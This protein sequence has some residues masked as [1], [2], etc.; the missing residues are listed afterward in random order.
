[1]A[2]LNQRNARQEHSDNCILCQLMSD[3][4]AARA[5]AQRIALKNVAIREYRLKS[6]MKRAGLFKRRDNGEGR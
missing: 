1:M 2:N 3:P 6:E 4:E 5:I